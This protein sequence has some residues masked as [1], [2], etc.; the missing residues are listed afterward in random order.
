MIKLI[1]KEFNRRLSRLNVNEDSS[2][3]TVGAHDA[4]E[5]MRDWVED[6]DR[7]ETDVKT[8]VEATKVYMRDS[9]AP[10]TA[11]LVINDVVTALELAD[12]QA[13][14][15]AI[16]HHLAQQQVAQLTE[17]LELKTRQTNEL[18]IALAKAEGLQ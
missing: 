15:A 14:A 16:N 12:Q 17:L 8:L 2:D 4:L 11:I 7:E 13:T 3:R 10:A 6:F 9:T 5:S 1:V 18:Q